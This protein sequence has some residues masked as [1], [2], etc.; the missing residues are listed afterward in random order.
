M[1]EISINPQDDKEKS[2]ATAQKSDELYLQAAL[3]ADVVKWILEK[4]ASVRLSEDP[5]LKKIPIVEFRRRMRVS[6]LEKF[7]MTT[8]VSVINFYLG[9][10]EMKKH[11]AIGAVV[12][13][14][15]EPY[16][17]N[18]LEKLGYPVRDDEDPDVLGASVGTL[19]NLV[20]GN[21]KAELTKWGYKDLAMSPFSSYM[22][23]VLNGI[24]FD[25]RQ[26]Q[27]Y[28]ITFRVK[29]KPLLDV[30]LTLGKI[31]KIKK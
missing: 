26:K 4:D 6:S 14:I 22:N 28:E 18:L 24:E 31:P 5:S 27:K 19:C 29:G 2:L 8:Y 10:R 11:A 13:Y 7:N 17:V 1:G 30:E 20:A 25:V 9:E 15:G 16:I 21:F 3:L 23:E 12:V